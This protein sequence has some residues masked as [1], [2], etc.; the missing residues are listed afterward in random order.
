MFRPLRTIF[1]HFSD[2]FSTFFGHF[3]DISFF[4]LSNDLP[5]TN[6]GGHPGPKPFT[7][8]LGAKQNKMFC[9]EVLDPKA[10]TSTTRGGVSEELYAGKLRADLSF[11][12]FH[13]LEPY[14]K[15]YSDTKW[16]PEHP[17]GVVRPWASG[18]NRAPQ[19]FQFTDW[20]RKVF[21][22]C[23]WVGNPHRSQK[24]MN[25]LGLSRDR[26]F[27]KNLIYVFFFFPTRWWPNNTLSVWCPP[28]PGKSSKFFAFSGFWFCPKQFLGAKLPALTQFVLIVL[29]S[30]SRCCW[31]PICQLHLLWSLEPELILPPQT[32]E[33]SLHGPL[34]IF[35][36]VLPPT[37]LP[38]CKQGRA[39]LRRGKCHEHEFCQTSLDSGAFC[40]RLAGG[41]DYLSCVRP[42][43]GLKIFYIR[44]VIRTPK[45]PGNGKP[46][47]STLR[48]AIKGFW[49]RWWMCK[50][51]LGNRSSPPGR[52]STGI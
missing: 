41:L 15:P 8:S 5:V 6:P 16:T 17:L 12:N 2:I 39:R 1:G 45:N 23:L 46:R 24:R 13:S 22:Q 43:G 51:E 28:S 50:R 38:P 25:S 48:G 31:C 26:D 19:R 29:V 37:L 34:D 7:P 27:P 52:K 35:L 33:H 11:S 49:E 9:V 32:N 3:V 40:V 20:I 21:L 44:P 36:D 47:E 18:P 10:R 30:W 14:T 42:V 4:W